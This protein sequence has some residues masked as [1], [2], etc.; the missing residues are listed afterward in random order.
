M[1][2]FIAAILLLFSVTSNAKDWTPVVNFSLEGGSYKET[3]LWVSGTSYAY[4]SLVKE[5]GEMKLFCVESVSSKNIL[6][7]LNAKYSNKS[8]S[9]EIAIKEIK[10]GLKERFPCAKD[11]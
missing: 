4:S 9:S 2:Y 11:S 1:K 6:D 8:I 10:H 5:M 3:L 7:I